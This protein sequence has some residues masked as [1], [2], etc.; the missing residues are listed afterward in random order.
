MRRLRLVN[1]YD[2]EVGKAAQLEAAYR[3][4]DESGY[5]R[6]DWV[7]LSLAYPET[8]DQE[9]VETVIRSWKK[10]IPEGIEFLALQGGFLGGVSH[11]TER[12]VHSWIQP[13]YMPDNFTL[14]IRV[15]PLQL[16]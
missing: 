12:G 8:P 10:H 1:E 5:N 2:A 7:Y 15:K 3:L 11:D 4:L 14:F 16:P 6:D 9:G 13:C